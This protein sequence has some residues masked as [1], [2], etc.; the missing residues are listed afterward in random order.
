MKTRAL[1]AIG[2]TGLQP[3]LQMDEAL[4]AN[5]RIKYYLALLQTATA[6]ADHPAEPASSLHA[7]RIASGVADAGFDL[8]VAETRREGGG[9]RI[10]HVHRLL[11]ALAD[12]L[13][14]LVA[15]VVAAGAGSGIPARLDAVIGA[16]PSG[17]EPLDGALI[18]EL[19]R[20]GGTDNLHQLV[21]DVH[22]RL[23]ALQAELAAERVDGASV[24]RLDADDR[25]LVRAFMAGLN[26]TAPLRF[27]HPGLATTATRSGGRLIIQNDVG[28]TQAH[29]LV[30]HVDGL[31]VALTY[32]DI[33]PERLAF[34]Q[35]MLTRFAVAWEVAGG[36]RR[37]DGASYLLAT[38]RFGAADRTELCAYLEW[39][40]SRLVF[41]I[42]WNRARKALRGFLRAPDRLTVLGWASQEEIGH[43]A[44]L[45]LGGA[46][47]INAAIEECAGSAMH[48]G[49]RLCDVIGNE[50]ATVF[51][52]FV[53]RTASAG[54]AARQTPS[55]LHDRIVAELRGHFS[56]E[57]RRLLRVAADHACLIFE[58][59][60]LLRDGVLSPD[61]GDAA[62]AAFPERARRYEHDADE[63]VIATRDAVRRRPEHAD[64]AHLLE[65]ADDAA[66]ELEDVVFLLN[67]LERSNGDVLAPLRELAD[68]VVAAAQEW[69]KATTDAAAAE[70][71]GSEDF[72]VALDQVAELEHRADDVERDLTRITVQ[73]AAD[74]RQ[75]HLVAT[76][77]RALEEAT[78]A[79][80]HASL[81]L[82]NH[83]LGTAG[84]G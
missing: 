56:N 26:R 67:L 2:E 47:I 59:A 10:P 81:I 49:D 44:F 50:A 8:S 70:R 17:E 55:L 6:H 58:I 62:V 42:D 13:H 27:G 9:Y 77:G 60:V 24:Y 4:A 30:V 36:E 11:A 48:F 61:S 74:F 33:H 54:L 35:Q 53:L 41:L 19:T 73:H 7:E 83:V 71:D 72:L 66:D 32:S 51:V 38:G 18:G 28:E 80:K 12:D 37:L 3:L 34:F 46:R 15:P 43:R 45:E 84:H 14:L 20:A 1:E 63:L 76:M 64:L 23:N 57:E 25:P 39:L 5:D 52:Q 40:G 69:I 16:L 31:D 75:L 68:I 29:V 22:K 79:L 65:S 78:D 82:R 21:M